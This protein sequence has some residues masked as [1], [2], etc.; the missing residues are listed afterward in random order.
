V[1]KGP[2]RAVKGQGHAVFI[3][4]QLTR[5]D[6]AFGGG[7]CQSAAGMTAQI[8]DAVFRLEFLNP[9]RNR[10]DDGVENLIAEFGFRI[11]DFMGTVH[12]V[13]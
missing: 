4:E 12:P 3:L 2:K 1:R 5:S 7:F 9:L 8:K 6:A 10:E 11:S 13:F